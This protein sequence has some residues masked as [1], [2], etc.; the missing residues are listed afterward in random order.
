MEKFR[1]T[2]SGQIMIALA[3]VISAIIVASIG[4]W[5]TSS[6]R[7]GKVEAQIQVVEE[8]EQNHFLE[9]KSDIKDVN[10]T[11]GK[12]YDVVNSK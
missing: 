9:L 6:S 5:A 11:L 7:V 3:G 2:K 1:R 4:A 8:R 12:I 10:T